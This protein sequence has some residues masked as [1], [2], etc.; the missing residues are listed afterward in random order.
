MQQETPFYP[1]FLSV[2]YV[3]NDQGAALEGI[4]RRAVEMLGD[5]VSDYE[6][7]IVDNA[8]TDGSL[9]VLQ[10]I[11]GAEGLPNVQ[12]FALGQKVDT[13]TAF[14]VGMEN[15]LGDFVA[16]LDPLTDDI[17][18]LPQMLA[19]ATAGVDVV[20]ARNEQMPQ[21]APAYRWSLAFFNKLYQW[22]SG[23]HLA[24]DAPQYR[25]LS[26]RVINYILQHAQPVISYRHLPARGGFARAN[27]RY[28]AAPMAASPK[29]LADSIDRGLRMV[30]ATS[31]TPLRLVT[32]L[33]LFGAGANVFYSIYVVFVSLFKA[34]V[35]PGWVS[36]S[37][38]QSGMFFLISLV[39]LVF[40]EYILHLARQSSDGPLYHVVQEFTS[41]RMTRREKLNI[42]DVGRKGEQ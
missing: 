5:L 11:T 39:L 34:D 25:L 18:F 32:W 9:Q 24:K 17:G 40:G 1:V 22:F 26:K 13:D 14:W 19:E 8:S 29:S 4:A 30:V 31:K 21:Q 6:L 42:E 33:S 37:L 27:M 16:A 15:A 2:V 38:Q 10:K 35:A 23:V 28:S 36:L 3:V 20:F 41:A 7:I 12:V